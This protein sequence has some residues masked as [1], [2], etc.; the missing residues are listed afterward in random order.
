MGTSAA[1]TIK[2]FGNF[3]IGLSYSLECHRIKFVVLTSKDANLLPEI[4][5]TIL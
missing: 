2:L 3:I 1:L 5:T 4:V